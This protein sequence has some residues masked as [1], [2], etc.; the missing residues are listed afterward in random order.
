M[1]K[2]SFYLLLF[3]AYVLPL[4]FLSAQSPKPVQSPMIDTKDVG[5]IKGASGIYLHKDIL[6]VIPERC[7]EII[8]LNTSG[9]KKAPPITLKEMPSS[10]KTL[11]GITI[12]NDHFFLIDEDRPRVYKFKMDGKYVDQYSFNAINLDADANDGFEG[13]AYNQDKNLLYVLHERAKL[14]SKYQA[15]IYTLEFNE[16]LAVFKTVNT[17]LIPLEKGLFRYSDI[18]FKNNHLKAIKS[19]KDEYYIYD[20]DIDSNGIPQLEPH[21]SRTDLTKF[22]SD[23]IEYNEKKDSKANRMYSTNLEGITLDE[24]NNI[25]LISDNMDGG[26]C[27][28]TVKKQTM[29]LRL[30]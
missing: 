26:T 30:K 14:N 9:I 28:E 1:K 21:Y 2:I 10:I 22:V 15:V 6:Y 19:R 29:L 7:G 11:E 12:I 27:D 18:C 4:K 8:Q 13:I 20:I 16:K 25:Y 17:I 23:A 5:E 3:L 24:K